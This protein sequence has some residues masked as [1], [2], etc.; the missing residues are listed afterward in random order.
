MPHARLSL[1]RLVP[2]MVVINIVSKVHFQNN[3]SVGHPTSNNV[4]KNTS[5]DS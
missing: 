2:D 5:R 3:L 1:K 4:S